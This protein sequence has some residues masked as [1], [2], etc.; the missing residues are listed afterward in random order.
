LTGHTTLHFP[1]YLVEA[2]V[3]EA[4]AMRVPR[5]RP[6]RL[7]LWAGLGIGTIGLAAEWAWSYIWWELPWTESMLPEA[8]IAA[9][10]TAVAGGVIGGFIGRALAS[11]W[12]QPVARPRRLVPIAALALVAV[13]I[14]AAPISQGDPVKATVELN[15]ITPAPHRTVKMT[16]RVDPEDAADDARWFTATA[17]QG[18]GSVVDRLKEV[19]PGVFETTKPIPVYGQWK[20]TLR[21]HKG[22]AVQGAAVYFPEDPAIP[23]PAVEAPS[24]FTREFVLDKKLLQ[25][26]QKPDVS[27]ALTTFAYIV[28]LMIAI[29]LLFSLT[30]GLRRLDRISAAARMKPGDEV[31]EQHVGANARRFE[32]DGN[33]DG[34]GAAAKEESAEKAGSS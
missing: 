11:P 23:A 19:A 9:L 6:I 10:I 32:R 15:D 26:E 3:V 25:R 28:V 21:L 24:T 20:T 18:G 29:G 13:F 33:G 14:Y 27:P 4:V 17:W 34:D 12:V 7:G 16:V 30:K 22:S 31:H 1:L 2:F 5:E 8:V